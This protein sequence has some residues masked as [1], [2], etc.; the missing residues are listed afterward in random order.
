MDYTVVDSTSQD[1]SG[2]DGEDEENMETKQS[3]EQDNTTKQDDGDKMDDSGTC[4]HV[5][6]MYMYIVRY[7]IITKIAVLTGEYSSVLP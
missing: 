1:D 4:S 6:Y 2:K 3:T 5:H 7:N